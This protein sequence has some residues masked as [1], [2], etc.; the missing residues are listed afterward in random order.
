MNR[1]CLIP[2]KK[3]EARK[4]GGTAVKETTRV[5]RSEEIIKKKKGKG[6]GNVIFARSLLQADDNSTG[7]DGRRGVQLRR[8]LRSLL[9]VQLDVADPG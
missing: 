4:E 7:A 2:P 5:G 1:F 8:P 3:K 6:C 9:H